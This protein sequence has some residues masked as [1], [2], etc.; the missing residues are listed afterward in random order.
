M[1]HLFFFPAVLLLLNVD[2]FVEG[3]GAP[4]LPIYPRC[5]PHPSLMPPVA[6]RD[7]LLCSEL[8]NGAQ[9]LL[10]MLLRMPNRLAGDHVMSCDRYSYW[11]SRLCP[12]GWLFSCVTAPA[13]T[14]E[15]ASSPVR[16]L[17]LHWFAE[18]FR[19]DSLML[20]ACTGCLPGVL[21]SCLRYLLP[22]QLLLRPLFRRGT[23]LHSIALVCRCGI[24]DGWKASEGKLRLHCPASVLCELI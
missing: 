8:Y 2:L 11:L 18:F 23:L 17:P 24:H 22:L 12:S 13:P 1:S 6:P 9:H 5:D 16:G 20:A 3:F 19:Y 10:H 7:D 21:V 15:H 14:S 4:S